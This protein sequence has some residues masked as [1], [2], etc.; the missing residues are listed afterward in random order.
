MNEVTVSKE[1]QELFLTKLR[2]KTSASHKQLEDNEYSKAILL[3]TVTLADYQTYIAK[4]YG[5]VVACE[6]DIFPL[7]NAV[8][9]DLELRYKA[10][11]ILK[12]LENTGVETRFLQNLPEYHFTVSNAA[13]AMGVMYVLEGST[14]GGK[15]LYKH[16]NQFLGLDA[17]NGASYFW[18]Y[19]QQTGLLWKTFIAALN[20]FAILEDCGDEII[21]HAVQTFLK[22]D[23]WLGTA[24][25]N[26][27][28]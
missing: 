7:I 8:I 18:G 16:I 15:F 17:Q 24:E 14:L 27:A 1:N 6:R 28:K 13:E 9:P 20:G 19:G 5:V 11:F 10:S 4:M 2:Q 22:I 3:P 21:S 25:I 12:D 23:N 26:L